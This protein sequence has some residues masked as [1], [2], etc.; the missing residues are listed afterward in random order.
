MK[1]KI[2]LA[3]ALLA[4]FIAFNAISAPKER[5]IPKQPKVLVS[6]S[7]EDKEW[8]ARH[9]WV[10][11][12]LKDFQTLKPG[13]TRA[14]IESKFPVNGG[15]TAHPNARFRHPSCH[16][17]KIDVEFKIDKEDK[18]REWGESDRSTKFSK[19]YIEQPFFD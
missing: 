18:N 9:K 19:P 8:K 14:E 6:G 10:A 15:I 1:S 12:C 5:E 4:I 11:E 2:T 7:K 16:Y 17:F 3:F 13:M